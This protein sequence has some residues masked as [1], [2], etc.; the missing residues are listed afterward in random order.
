MSMEG[1]RVWSGQGYEW[2]K[3]MKGIRAWRGQG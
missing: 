3:G 2:D 1:T